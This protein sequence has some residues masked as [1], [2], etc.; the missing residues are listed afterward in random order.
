MLSI[1]ASW[2]DACTAFCLHCR[3]QI[4]LEPG[5]PRSP[6]CWQALQWG[7]PD[8]VCP[9]W[10]AAGI[11]AEGVHDGHEDAASPGCGGGHGGCNEGLSKAQAIGQ[12]QGALAE[13][14]NKER[15]HPLAQASL[16]EAL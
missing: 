13:S 14:T 3:V 15:G 5:K 6:D 10:L 8:L 16:L 11:L 2:A 1:S 12:A 4:D 7:L 9:T